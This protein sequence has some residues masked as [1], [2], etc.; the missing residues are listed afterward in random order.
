LGGDCFVGGSACA[1]ED[2]VKKVY[3]VEFSSKYERYVI[4]LF[5]TKER[6]E[7]WRKQHSAYMNRGVA[8]NA[9]GY[10]R[11]KVFMWG[12]D[13]DIRYTIGGATDGQ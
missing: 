7:A 10:H 12:V 6:A 1:T 4:A 8:K 13:S 3:A 11:Y 9:A 5:S 2:S